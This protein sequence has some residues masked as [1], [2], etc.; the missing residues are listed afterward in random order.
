MRQELSASNTVRVVLSPLTQIC[1]TSPV[2]DAESPGFTSSSAS[3]WGQQ[4]S[5][6]LGDFFKCL[7]AHRILLNLGRILVCIGQYESC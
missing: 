5:L 1:A 4:T 3:H 2:A 7:V 6:K